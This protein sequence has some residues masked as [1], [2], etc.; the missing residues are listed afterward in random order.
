MYYGSGGGGRG[1]LVGVRFSLTARA[2]AG[3]A[4]H[5]L[6]VPQWVPILLFALLPLTSAV[7]RRRERSRQRRTAHGLC[8]SC[9]YDLR[10]TPERCPECGTAAG[11]IV[12][13]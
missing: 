3:R 7:A 9:G 12:P 11:G 8:L 1:A 6:S 13:R 10:A 2:D 4:L 5:S